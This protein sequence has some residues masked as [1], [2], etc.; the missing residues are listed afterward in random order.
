[1]SL[2]SAD[3]PE[4]VSST[5]VSNLKTRLGLPPFGPGAGF[6][7]KPKPAASRATRSA[8]QPKRITPWQLKELEEHEHRIAAIEERIALLD[9]Q[10]ADP[11]LYT[12][13]RE[14]A[15]ELQ[16][17][18]ATLTEEMDGLYERWEELESLR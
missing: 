15:Q 12:G 2:L 16:S 8:E 17:E 3:W 6:V 13:P 11:A 9:Q 1:M 14:T 18:R 4:E 10:L 7:R 5:V